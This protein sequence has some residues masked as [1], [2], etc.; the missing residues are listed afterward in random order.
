MNRYKCMECG[1]NQF[2]SSHLKEKEPC[3]Y[4][5][6]TKT[7]LMDNIRKLIKEE[8][9]EVIDTR[10]PRGLFYGEEGGLFIGIDNTTGDAWT[11]EFKT[12]ASCFKWLAGERA[13]DAHG[14]WLNG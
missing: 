5:G 10:E 1:G 14:Q 8:M 7:K 4:C 3:I 11:E 2:S 9:T 12:K 6:S 13:K